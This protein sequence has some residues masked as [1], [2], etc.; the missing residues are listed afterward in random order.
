MFYFMKISYFQ[1][2]VSKLPF[3]ASLLI[4]LLCICDPYFVWAEVD[5]IDEGKSDIAVKMLV[6]P[7]SMRVIE[8]QVKT[9]GE[10]EALFS[11]SKR[12]QKTLLKV[13]PARIAPAKSGEPF[14][15]IVTRSRLLKLSKQYSEDVIFIFRRVLTVHAGTLTE[16]KIRYQGMLYLARQKKVLVLKGNEK[17]E[18]LSGSSSHQDRDDL[19]KNLDEKGLKGLAKEARIA[20]HSHKFEKRQ[21]AY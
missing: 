20:L 19:W 1:E 17:N 16:Y 14:S 10:E 6:F 12:I 9:A 18:P 13:D 4:T 3:L 21:S 8:N 7:K 2:K 15:G 5:L 11:D